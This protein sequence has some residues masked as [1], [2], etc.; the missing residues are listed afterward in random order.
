[1][2]KIIAIL[3][4]FSF[5]QVSGQDKTPPITLT[6]ENTEIRDVLNKIEETLDYRFY[7]I[8]D[9]IKDQK[10]TGNYENVPLNTLLE[11]IFK[12]T[13]INFYILDNASIILTA[14]NRVY[15]ELPDYF[16]GDT[17]RD[18]IE[19]I[20]EPLEEDEINPV[21]Y[22]VEKKGTSKR[23]NVVRIGKENRDNTKK[24]YTL[25]G[26]VT[27]KITGEIIPNLAIVV[28]GKNTGTTT[29]SRGFYELKLSAG[30][31]IIETSSLG[32]QKTQTEVVIY[33][34][35][36]L[37]FDLQEAFE[38]LDEVVL[39]AVDSDKN[40]ADTNTGV[41]KIEVKEIKN[42]PLVLGERDILQVATTLP[43]IS[44]TGEGSSGYNV[45]GGKEDQNL[46]LLDN[47]V[48][49][50]PTHF[51]GIFSSLNPFT[52]GD[53]SIFKGN[54]PAKYGGRLSSVFDIKTKDANTQK[55][56]GEV[57]IGPVTSNVTLELPIIKDKAGL[58]VGARGTY[59]DW[60]LK[61][62]DDESLNKSEASFY[63]VIAKYNYRINDNND[64]KATAYMSTDRF[65]ITTD[66]LFS[67][68]NRLFS[69]EWNH[70]F[71]KKNRGSIILTNSNYDF[72]IELDSD[73]DRNFDLGYTINES[74]LK[75]NMSYQP[76]KN[77][78]FN[79]GVSSKLY[80]VEPGSVT[81]RGG[82]SI[83]SPLIIPDERALESAAYLSGNFTLSDKLTVDAG[84]RYSTYSFLGD[85][86]QNVYQEGLPK[87]ESTLIRVDEFDKNEVVETYN[88]FE[89]RLA[90]RY[91]IQDDLSIKA[92]YSNTFQ[93]I[94]LLTNNTTLSPTDTWKLSDLNIKPQEAT[95]ISA[96]I[97][98][99]LEDDLYELSLEGFYKTSKNILDYKVGAQLLL[100]ETL[101]TEVLEG[102][103]RAYGLEFLI[104]KTRG[105]LNGW[106]GYTY[107]RSFIKLDSEFGAERVNNG[108]Y[109]ASNF[110][111]P[112]D[113]SLVANYK[114]TRRFSLSMNF[115]YQTGRPVTFPVGKF[116]FNNSEFVVFSDRNEFRIPDYYR[117]DIGFN[118]EGN[119][120]IKKFAHSF[121]NFSI[122][123]VL[124][125]NNPFS[126]FF[127]TDDGE[128]KAF[129]TSIFS[130]PVPTITYNF[131][132][133]ILSNL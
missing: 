114:M 68:S 24:A 5:Y 122:F 104:K 125:R 19:K 119:H 47:G 36:R 113:I 91:L 7:Y 78:K 14:N 74:E 123:N 130:V 94:H 132:F 66:S 88:G 57:S 93:Y 92:S 11:A 17:Q 27:N 41:A 29:D 109:F 42:I 23:G 89:A 53:V 28:K 79:Y 16:F 8:D 30:L 33:N 99:N 40:V 10:I 100:N 49:Y 121:W 50:N 12:E 108:E 117:L 97:F 107:S 124:G 20:E 21:F 102:E 38:T 54:I 56:A 62:L 4:I 59:S 75:L 110:D 39:S 129:K 120:K 37:D 81:P 46:I 25:S 31:N 90:A 60:I 127:V 18:S 82:N 80:N 22:A 70:K 87:S 48:L 35:G 26:Y 58:I 73:G 51:F 43:G 95:Q 115:V 86:S 103:G 32:T 101:E 98:K 77:Y 1:M 34:N 69:F 63:D 126:V 105:K 45:R 85:I 6:F 2:K 111:K 61:S 116:E 83:I 71:N 64:I 65:S 13:V 112:H 131:R 3:L 44:K 15:G 133:R 52:T 128:I 84:L 118:M 72:D 67:Y 55:I 96:G 76:N 106:L 9:W